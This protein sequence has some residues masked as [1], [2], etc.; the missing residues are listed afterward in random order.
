MPLSSYNRLMVCGECTVITEDEK[1]AVCDDGGDC[2]FEA[3]V[4]FA[5]DI[6]F[7][8]RYLNNATIVACDNEATTC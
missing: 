3:R 7:F 6:A 2:A 8:R 1:Y 5:E 4:P